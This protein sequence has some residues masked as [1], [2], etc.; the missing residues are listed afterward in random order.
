MHSARCTS[1][2]PDGRQAVGN[3]QRTLRAR[4]GGEFV[5]GKEC[6]GDRSHA[7][8]VAIASRGARQ[9]CI[10]TLRY[11]GD[12]LAR[13]RV[14]CVHREYS[15]AERVAVWQRR[16]GSGRHRAHVCGC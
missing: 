15:R 7:G 5:I 9:V 10:T 11:A 4:R 2:L 16:R 13:W 1:E 8:R 14:Q 6:Q 12:A 3:T